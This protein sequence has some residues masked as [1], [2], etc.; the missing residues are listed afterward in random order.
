[1]PSTQR[2]EMY[3]VA[4]QTF[5]DVIIDYEAYP[6]FVDNLTGI[7]IVRDDAFEPRITFH[8]HILK[9]FQY[10]L[11][12]Y[13]DPPGVVAWELVDGNV[14]KTMD[15]SWELRK[16]GR[17]RTE[18]TYT[19]DIQLRAAVPKLSLNQLVKVKL[20]AMMKAFYERARANGQ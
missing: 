14:F 19:L 18:V 1:M 11:D 6:E 3:D 2:T 4:I 10:T 12:L 16:K 9:D 8:P 5:Y 13:H 17:N 15:G 20:P 7:T